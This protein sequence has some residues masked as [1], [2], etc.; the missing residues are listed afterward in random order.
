MRPGAR[1]QGTPRIDLRDSNMGR[2]DPAGF[3]L[4]ALRERIGGRDRA[5]QLVGCPVGDHDL[6]M[7]GEPEEPWVAADRLAVHVD[8]D[9]LVPAAAV[10]PYAVG[11]EAHP[12]HVEHL[13]Q[14]E[15]PHDGGLDVNDPG[16][17]VSVQRGEES[18]SFV[19]PDVHRNLDTP[20]IHEDIE[21]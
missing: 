17:V 19:D 11:G 3:A 9:E 10:A 8:P 2:P 15:G 12:P 7:S 13:A 4:E 1:W 5:R 18:L 20:P 21:M 6:L 16:G 14:G